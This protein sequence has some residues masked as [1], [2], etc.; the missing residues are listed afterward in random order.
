MSL[1]QFL[2]IVWARRWLIMAAT[3]SC[4]IGA[5]IVTFILPARWDAHSR[6]LLNLL[7]PDPVTGEVITSGATNSYVSTQI[8]L[9]KDYAVAGQ[10][11]D[12]LGWLSD[13][14]LISQYN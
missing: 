10:V 5:F 11:A 1:V 8:E 13:P 12:Q 14:N 9:I 3:V 7:K 2:R 6:V 4:V